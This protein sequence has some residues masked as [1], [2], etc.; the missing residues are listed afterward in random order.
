MLNYDKLESFYIEYNDKYVKGDVIKPFT[1]NELKKF[2]T[3]EDLYKLENQILRNRI[4]KIKKTPY[5]RNISPKDIADHLIKQYLI[6]KTV[7]SQLSNQ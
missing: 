6:L 2:I 5:S 1:Y 4:R 7:I 3:K